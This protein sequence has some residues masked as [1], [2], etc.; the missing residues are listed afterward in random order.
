MQHGT[1][2]SGKW[3][4]ILVANQNRSDDGDMTW[5]LIFLHFL[6]SC[7]CFNFYGFCKIIHF[8]PVY[9]AF[10]SFCTGSISYSIFVSDLKTRGFKVIVRLM[11]HEVADLEPLLAMLLRENPAISEVHLFNT[12]FH[13]SNFTHARIDNSIACTKWSLVTNSWLH[14]CCAAGHVIAE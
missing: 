13:S 5:S 3:R 11:P 12:H 2:N 8:T 9:L 6:C 1:I 7:F 4:S 10:F 14:I